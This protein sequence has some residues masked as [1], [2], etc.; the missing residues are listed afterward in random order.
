M[1]TSVLSF[2]GYT[3]KFALYKSN[4]L[5]LS[6]LLKSNADNHVDVAKNEDFFFSGHFVVAVA[7][8]SGCED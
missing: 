4:P 8:S 2:L 7:L 5:S 1:C 6:L 3:E